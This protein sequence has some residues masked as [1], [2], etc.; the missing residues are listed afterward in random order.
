MNNPGGCSGLPQGSIIVK[1][2]CM[3][4][5]AVVLDVGSPVEKSLGVTTNFYPASEVLSPSGVDFSPWG[6]AVSAQTP[7][8][9][10]GFGILQVAR[11]VWLLLGWTCCLRNSSNLAAQSFQA[12]ASSGNLLSWCMPDRDP[13][14]PWVMGVALL[15]QP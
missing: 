8:K 7:G 1:R 10:S 2:C 5:L 9:L 3:K 15:I 11:G 14:A 13:P 6:D 4:K 12:A